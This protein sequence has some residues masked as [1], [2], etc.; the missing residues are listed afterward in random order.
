MGDPVFRA[1]NEKRPYLAEKVDGIRF[2]LFT[3]ERCRF[4]YSFYRLFYQVVEERTDALKVDMRG[5][6]RSSAGE[7]AKRKLRNLQSSNIKVYR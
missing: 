1:C 6:L 2:F 7:P 5:G 4:S 3:H